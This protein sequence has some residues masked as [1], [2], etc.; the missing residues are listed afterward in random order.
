MKLDF[1]K[2]A[3]ELRR[4]GRVIIE[5]AEGKVFYL[6][7][8]T[9][10]AKSPRLSGPNEKGYMIIKDRYGH[11]LST[12]KIFPSRDAFLNYVSSA[13]S[14]LSTER[15]VATLMELHDVD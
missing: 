10:T 4:Y 7:R 5:D 13:L 6:S 1:E 14:L 2:L 12:V 3:H 15:I 9:P 8:E 11:W